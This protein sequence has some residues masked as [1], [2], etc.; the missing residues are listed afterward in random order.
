MAK[1]VTVRAEG[2]KGE[3]RVYGWLTRSEAEAL[4]RKLE[5]AGW[6]YTEEEAK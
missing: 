3:K 6:T 2:T 1:R 4:K 5:E